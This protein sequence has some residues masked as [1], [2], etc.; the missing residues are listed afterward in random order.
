MLANRNC[1]FIHRFTLGAFLVL[2][3]CGANPRAIF[4]QAAGLETRHDQPLCVDLLLD[5]SEYSP[6]GDLT[7]D[8]AQLDALLPVLARRSGELREWV[9]R[10]SV[11]QTTIVATVHFQASQDVNLHVLER[12]R[13]AAVRRARTQLLSAAQ[14]VRTE[15]PQRS[16]LFEAIT[17]IALTECAEHERW[18]VLVS[19]LKEMSQFAR[20]ECAP[21]NP[22]AVIPQLDAAQLL[23]P[24]SLRG[25]T[26]V[27][28]F[29][30]IT[31]ATCHDT[32][33]RHLELQHAWQ[34]IL[35]RAGARAV[36][37]TGPYQPQGESQ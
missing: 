28:A 35:V 4:E 18:I 23:R 1:A 26:V 2:S 9:L 7:K 16:A 31:P 25:I 8:T 13:A 10:R 37:T 17:R 24:R 12:D 15:I 34:A 11:E 27:A 36:F 5:A 20:A 3:A 19:D 6:G 30:D 14:L 33:A 32:V 21:I 22:A 29:F